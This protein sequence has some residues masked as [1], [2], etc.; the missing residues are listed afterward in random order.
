MQKR[1]TDRTLK[2]LKP[3]SPGKR[4]DVRDPQQPGLVVRVTDKGTRSFMLQARYPGSGQPT[5]RAI[6]IYPEMTL[7]TA[8][9][10]A[11]KWRRMLRDGVDPTSEEHA[12]HLKAIQRR[13]QTF[14]VVAEAFIAEIK[15]KRQRKAAEVERDLK[16]EFVPCWR[17]RPISSI[18]TIDVVTVID[19]VV[20]RGATAQAHNLLGHARRFFAWTIA[21]GCYGIAASPCD[22]LKPK[23]LIGTRAVRTRVLTEHELRAFWRATGKLGYPYG[24]LFQLLLVTIQRKSE[25]ALAVR[26]EID[27]ER[28]LWI[29][30]PERMKMDA[31]HVVPLSPLAVEL[32]NSLPSFSRGPY[33]FSTTHGQNAVNGFS[34]AKA[35][36]DDL[37]VHELHQI[38][39]HV[40]DAFSQDQLRPWVIHDLRR[41]GRTNLSALPIADLVRELVIAHAKPGLHKVYD[42]YAYLDEKRRALEVWGERLSSII[43]LEP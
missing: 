19:S 3:A 26:S 37:M 13:E 23:E 14:E 33:L 12:A 31:P 6:G 17:N 7:E 22:P 29:I 11:H 10:K 4:Y 36:L 41:T 28:K 38:P 5:R 42:Q 39:N 27:V 20:G 35:R 8:R 25:V 9:E 40:G 24:P 32:I 21:R 43:D 18:T 2:S 34:K 16:R 15:R 1:L 30:P